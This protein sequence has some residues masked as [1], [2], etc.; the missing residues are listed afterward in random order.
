M[1]AA[2]V[3]VGLRW[4]SESSLSCATPSS[5]W[6]EVTI[7][8]EPRGRAFPIPLYAPNGPSQAKAPTIGQL[9]DKDLAKMRSN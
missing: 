1:E 2:E 9:R 6:T 4:T 5:G 3:R 8:P 7:S